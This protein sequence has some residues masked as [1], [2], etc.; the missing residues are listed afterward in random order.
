M[1]DLIEEL[2][3]YEASKNILLRKRYDHV[4]YSVDSNSFYDHEAAEHGG[5]DVRDLDDE[6]LE[7]RRKHNIFEVRDRV[8]YTG[9]A[10]DNDLY[11]LK[12]IYSGHDFV[13]GSNGADKDFW[14][15]F[16]SEI[17]HATDEEIKAGRRL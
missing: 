15:L 11:T 17:R 16:I 7:Y 3:G 14:T 13:V 10:N 4:A 9:R 2:G 12:E 8:F 5:I 1:S 6:L